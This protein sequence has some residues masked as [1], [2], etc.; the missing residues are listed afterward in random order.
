MGDV[1]AVVVGVLLALAGL[2]AGLRLHGLTDPQWSSRFD[3]APGTRSIR[4]IQHPFLPFTGRPGATLDGGRNNAWGFPT[5]EFSFTKDANDFVVVALGGAATHGGVAEAPE[6]WPTQLQRQLAAAHPDRNIRVY[7]LG[8]DG[9]TSVASLVT[10]SLVGTH[11]QP[12][13]VVVLHGCDEMRAL[14][15]ADFRPDHAH[16]L[17]NVDARTGLDFVQE[18]LPGWL[19]S[20]EIVRVVSGA[21]DR[22]RGAGSLDQDPFRERTPHADP[23]FGI[24]VTLA[25]L[26]AI[27]EV[28]VARGGDALFATYPFGAGGHDAAAAGFNDRLRRFFVAEGLPWVDL[29][30]GDRIGDTNAP[31]PECSAAAAMQARIAAALAPHVDA[32]TRR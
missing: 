31:S 11:L 17:R 26:R 27:R 15:A 25:N 24:D 3:T 20:F 30:A 21:I 19:L 10:L 4:R 16:Y 12:D 14:G 23:L 22:G 18:R 5:H 28:A 1:V 2:E 32:R 8:L 9:G 6:V 7:N 29:A 13:L